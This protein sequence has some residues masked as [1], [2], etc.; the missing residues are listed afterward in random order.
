M[1]LL[2]S[3]RC[4]ILLYIYSQT[5]ANHKTHAGPSMETWQLVD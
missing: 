3:F 4:N 1:F 2:G 5:Y